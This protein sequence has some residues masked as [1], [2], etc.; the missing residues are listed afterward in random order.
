MPRF[1]PEAMLR[2][3]ADHGV[4]YVLIGGLAATLHGSPLRTGDVDICPAR[5]EE[6]LTRLAA[7][8]R[9]MG[10]RVRSPDSPNGLA[11][12]CDAAFFRSLTLANLTT[13]FGDLDVALTPSGTGGYEDL[14]GSQ[15]EYDLGGLIVPVAALA[16]VIRS[17][18]SANR[19]RDRA[20]LPT[21]RAL[22][23]RL[24]QPKS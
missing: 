14:R 6:N 17:K 3:L 2:I 7:A 16:D 1:D 11:F 10:A 15:V 23:E 19:A 5:D 22:L 21:L 24:R 8:L 12:A 20:S 18:E 4:A 13:R 9:A